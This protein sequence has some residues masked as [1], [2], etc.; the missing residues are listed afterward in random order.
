MDHEY[1]HRIL[2][3]LKECKT[4]HHSI[5]SDLELINDSSKEWMVTLTNGVKLE[6]SIGRNFPF[7]SPFVKFVNFDDIHGLMGCECESCWYSCSRIS[8]LLV[9]VHM[10][11]EARRTRLCLRGILRA[12]PMMMLWRKR[13]TER[14]YHP[15]R[16][17]FVTE[18][19]LLF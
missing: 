3:E 17:D 8:K 10:K 13:A 12:A 5:V 15:S 11:T 4:D 16:I 18:H 1:Q 19:S 9:I 2:K 14:L 6:L 7:Q